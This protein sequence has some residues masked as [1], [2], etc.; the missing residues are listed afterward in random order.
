MR[1]E[2]IEDPKLIDSSRA[3]RIARGSGKAERDV[4]ELVNQYNMMK[5]MMKTLKRRQTTIMRKFQFA[6]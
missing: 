5:K 2:E 1:R 3:R 4:K 6:A